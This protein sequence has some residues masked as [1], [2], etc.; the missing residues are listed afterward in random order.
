MMKQTDYLKWLIAKFGG[1]SPKEAISIAVDN[2]ILQSNQKELPIKLSTVAKAIG[3]NPIP[4]FKDQTPYGQ[5]IMNEDGLFQIALRMKS[6]F[7][8]YHDWYTNARLRFSYAHELVH[9]LHYDFSIIPP[10]RVAPITLLNEEEV[11]CNFGAS[12]ILLPIRLVQI[13]IEELNSKDIVEVASNLSKKALVSLHT[14]YLYLLNNNFIIDIKNKLYI[15]SLKCEGYRNRGENKPRFII[16]IYYTNNSVKKEFM[17]PY[18]G[19]EA[20]DQDWSLERFHRNL[21]MKVILQQAVRNEIIMYKNKKYILNGNHFKI[22]EN[23]VWSDLSFIE[24]S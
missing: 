5:L 13:F 15:L 24:M 16:A 18:K 12:L 10:K 11:I 20:I 2:L 23:Y 21:N 17:P 8:S 4:I 14:S 7:F 3:I 22:S 9:C 6:Q 1:N 19:I